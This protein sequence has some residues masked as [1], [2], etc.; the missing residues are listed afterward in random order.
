MELETFKCEL[1]HFLKLS[2]VCSC[3]KRGRNF[4]K[5]NK[6]KSFFKS[7]KNYGRPPSSSLQGNYSFVLK[8]IDLG[9]IEFWE[10]RGLGGALVS[11]VTQSLRLKSQNKGCEGW[12]VQQKR[13]WTSVALSRW[14]GPKKVSDEVQERS[15][16]KQTGLRWGCRTEQTK[17]Q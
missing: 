15:R 4:E 1:Q 2:K 16:G 12:W 8:G 13:L 10:T 3:R 9:K 5:G 17:T 11:R 7:I 14:I 6:Q